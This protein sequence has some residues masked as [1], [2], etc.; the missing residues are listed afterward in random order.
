MVP[1]IAIYTLAIID[2]RLVIG[3]GVCMYTGM[4]RSKMKAS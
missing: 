2:S 3:V 4:R 1:D